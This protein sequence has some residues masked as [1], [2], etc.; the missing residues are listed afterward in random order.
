MDLSNVTILDGST[1]YV[2]LQNGLPQDEIFN[3][4]WSAAAFVDEKYHKL[5]TFTHKQYLE[6]GATHITTNSYAVQPMYYERFFGP[7]FEKKMVEHA[8]LSVELA[9]KAREEYLAE[10]PGSDAKVTIMGCLPPLTESHR[11]DLFNK[12]LAEKGEEFFIH[13]YKQLANALLKGGVDVLLFETMNC[14][15]EGRL[16]LE[17]MLELNIVDVPIYMSFEGSIRDEKLVP[18]PQ[19]APEICE[20]VLQ[21]KAKGLP[22]VM[23][24]W[25]CAPPEDIEQN[26]EVLE[27]AGMLQKLRNHAVGMAVYANMHERKVYD[28]GFAVDN[29]DTAAVV[30]QEEQDVPD[31]P[32][33]LSP[34]SPIVRRKDLTEST[35]NDPFAG[36]TDFTG[37]F[38]RKFG[39]CA[40]GGCCGC[41]PLGIKAVRE[42][43]QWFESTALKGA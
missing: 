18:Q 43:L 40:V 39:V 10:H 8:E 27:S 12:A 26:F 3:Q 13:H 5:V 28:E 37:R 30:A 35:D 23:I 1:G 4:I 2:L 32:T 22:I 24:G 29:I 7:G 36:Y 6:V 9:V 20:N 19:L 25:N 16:G 11:P 15:E 38:V 17:A 31:P 34:K 14:W 42:D 21:Y 33:P 41:G